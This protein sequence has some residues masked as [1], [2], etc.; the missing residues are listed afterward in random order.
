ML[1]YIRPARTLLHHIK[2][3]GIGD[4]LDKIVKRHRDQS[5]NGNGVIPHFSEEEREREEDDIWVRDGDEISQLNK[6][7]QIVANALRA[8]VSRRREREAN[9][10][11]CQESDSNGGPQ[12]AGDGFGSPPGRSSSA[13]QGSAATGADGASQRLGLGICGFAGRRPGLL[14]NGITEPRELAQSTDTGYCDL[15]ATSLFIFGDRCIG[16][17]V[18]VALASTHAL[19][20]GRASALGKRYAAKV[21]LF[22]D[23]GWASTS[24]LVSLRYNAVH[25]SKTKSLFTP[26]YPAR[27]VEF[28]VGPETD[29]HP[30]DGRLH[31]GPAPLANSVAACGVATFQASLLFRL[32]GS[33]EHASSADPRMRFPPMAPMQNYLLQQSLKEVTLTFARTGATEQGDDPSMFWARTAQGISTVNALDLYHVLEQVRTVLAKTAIKDDFA[34]MTQVE[35]AAPSDES[36]KSLVIRPIVFETHKDCADSSFLQ[37]HTLLDWVAHEKPVFFFRNR[38]TA[39]TQGMCSVPACFDG[40]RAI[41]SSPQEQLRHAAGAAAPGGFFAKENGGLLAAMQGAP[42]AGKMDA[43]EPDTNSMNAAENLLLCQN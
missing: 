42:A 43:Q 33:A 4:R 13:E 30:Y 41:F 37:Y 17:A 38:V 39:V 11:E 21:G 36:Q 40:E 34:E 7:Q 10:F 24:D 27:L 5:D 6:L 15:R 1:R 19:L 22:F 26:Y 28:W 14:Y 12:S 8:R 2:R 18:T 20:D 23:C 9:W 35:P 25:P 16:V 31:I 3:L 32:R 29:T